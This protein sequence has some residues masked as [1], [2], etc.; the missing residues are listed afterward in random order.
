MSHGTVAVAGIGSTKHGFFPE[1]GW[2]DL[3]V[4]AAYD[5][6]DDSGI[7]PDEIDGGYVAITAPETIEQQNLGPI[8]AEELAL[9]P[10]PFTQVVAA[11]AAGLIALRAGADM[12]A[13][14]RHRC[15]LVV[16]VEKISDTTAT[17]ESMMAYPDQDFET[18]LGFD[19]VDH[20]ALMLKRYLERYGQTQEAIAQFAVQDRWYAQRNPKA[21]DY[22]RPSLSVA[23]VLAAPIASRPFTGAEIAKACDGA[24]AVLLMASDDVRRRADVTVEIAGIAQ[25]TGPNVL[26][27]RFGW[28][29]FGKYDIAEALAT[30]AAAAR[31]YKEAGLAPEDV[32]FAEV[33][34]CFD[35]M[36]VLQL[37]A[38]G[39]FPRGRG[40]TAV[41]AGETALDGRCPACTDGGRISLGH[42]TG[43]TGIN[44]VV[45]AVVQMRGDAGERQVPRPDVAVCQSMG[46]NNATSAVAVLRRS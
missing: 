25:A 26:G 35:F 30:D 14:G 8:V 10:E 19:F 36:G 7:D 43:A 29:G 3:V 20:T 42:P 28:P 9:T 33:H 21:V 15:V 46:G 22:G 40:A 16:G 6:I 45:E 5:A 41:A 44:V 32:D 39:I 34:D 17:A 18:P 23:D 27:S 1:L 2:R 38:L 24:S 31:A 12:I 4:A 13:S 37:E 11:C